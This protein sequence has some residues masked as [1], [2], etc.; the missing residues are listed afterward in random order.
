L[1]KQR[2]SDEILLIILEMLQP[3]DVLYSLVGINKRLNDIA[4]DIISRSGINLVKFPSTS[5]ICSPNQS[6]FDRL[7]FD[8]LPQMHHYIK[9]M[10]I[11]SSSA[12]CILHSVDYPNLFFLS[13]IKLIY[14]MFS[15][16]FTG[17]F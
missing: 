10:I 3:I 13:L 9:L 2:G 16:Y 5:C 14:A 1:N 12:G 15:N 7:C 6:E 17:I 8:T 11:E 4:G